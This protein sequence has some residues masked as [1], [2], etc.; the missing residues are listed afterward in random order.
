MYTNHWNS[1]RVAKGFGWGFIVAGLLIAALS[2]RTERF[3]MFVRGMQASALIVSVIVVLERCISVGLLDLAQ[4]YRATGPFMSMHTGGQHIDAY[5]AMALPFAFLPLSRRTWLDF[6]ARGC[7]LLLC[8]YAIAATMS[9]GII[10]VAGITSVLLVLLSIVRPGQRRA[11]WQMYAM[12][13]AASVLVVVFAFVAISN[14]AIAQRFTDSRR[15][16]AARWHQWEELCQAADQTWLTRFFGNGLG[17][18]PGIAS[19]AFHEPLRTSELVALP[20]SRVA[21]KIRPGKSVYVEQVVNIDAPGP[22]QLR[23]QF[24]TEGRIDLHTYVCR[25]SLFDS[26]RCSEMAFSGFGQ[27]SDW[28]IIQWSIDTK[29]LLPPQSE[30]R[31]CAV[32]LAFSA[33]HDGE[34]VDVRDLELT[35]ARGQSLLSNADFHDGSARWFFT[36]DEHS[37]W[38]AENMW[39]HLYL[40]QGWLGVVSIAL[41]I[42]GT[43]GLLVRQIISGGDLETYVLTT[44]IFGFLAIGLLGSMLETPWITTMFC[45]LLAVSHAKSRPRGSYPANHMAHGAPT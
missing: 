31:Y 30:W 45:T 21:L 33:S 34:S 23:G 26:F 37:A 10:V 25:K 18:V 40:E 36:S 24:R 14:R 1:L 39:V 16:F 42:L 3:S 2:E 43:L 29:H 35:D 27:S 19:R 7:L 13:A 11:V 44:A 8:Y 32:T 9:R 4:L 12:A 15:D 28:Q 17:T 6:A 5:W 22:W 20:D 41:L 38:R